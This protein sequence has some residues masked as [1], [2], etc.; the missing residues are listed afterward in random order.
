MSRFPVKNG[1]DML[2]FLLL[3]GD[4]VPSFHRFVTTDR[5]ANRVR[6]LKGPA[7]LVVAAL[8]CV[9][10][11]ARIT[12]HGDKHPF[13]A[14]PKFSFRKSA[15]EPPQKV[16]LDAATLARDPI[17]VEPDW[18]EISH[19]ADFAAMTA[20]ASRACPSLRAPPAVLHTV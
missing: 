9:P 14:K 2:A 18:S 20:S 16:L 12:E 4:S 13:N 17:P 6:W 11:L 3:Q 5:G 7:M 19:I 10:T 1:P 15:E 8:L